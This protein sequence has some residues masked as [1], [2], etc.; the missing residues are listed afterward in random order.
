V[1]DDSFARGAGSGG[2]DGYTS[3]APSS[4]RSRENKTHLTGVGAEAAGAVD[5]FERSRDRDLAHPASDFFV[6]S[7]SDG[8]AIE[9]P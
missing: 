9:S 7:P 6:F 1:E 5:L 3:G 8:V 4:L 2:E